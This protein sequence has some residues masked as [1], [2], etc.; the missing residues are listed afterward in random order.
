V[1]GG[2]RYLFNWLE[3]HYQVDAVEVDGDSGCVRVTVTEWEKSSTGTARTPVM[4][5]IFDVR[6]G[7]LMGED[8][9]DA[10]SSLLVAIDGMRVLGEEDAA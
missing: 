1:T 8:D 9:E 3:D 6:T 5:A 10:L 2:S 7:A 4:R